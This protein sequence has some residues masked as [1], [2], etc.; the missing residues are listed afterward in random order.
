M[1]RYFFNIHDHA[2]RPDEEG[3][4]LAG[5]EEAHLEAIRF[6][7]NVIA[8]DAIH[9]AKRGA[10]RLEVEND[11]GAMLFRFDF[12]SGTSPAARYRA[13]LLTPD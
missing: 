9:I 7:G 3:T 12:V 1:P 8:E 4:E 2:S 5:I 10:W 11:A 6:A 13:L